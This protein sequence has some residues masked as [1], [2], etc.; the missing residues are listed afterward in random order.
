MAMLD[1]VAIFGASAL[2]SQNVAKTLVSKVRFTC[3]PG[4]S[5]IVSWVIW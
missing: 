4:K 1:P 3:S 5:S 2:A